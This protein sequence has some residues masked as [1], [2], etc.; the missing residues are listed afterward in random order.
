MGKY[1]K[2]NYVLITG[3][4]GGLGNA[5]CELF[6]SKKFNLFLTATNNERLVALKTKLIQQHPKIKIEIMACDLSNEESVPRPS[7]FTA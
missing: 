7:K 2:D 4:T 3:A 6:A 1:M 5:F